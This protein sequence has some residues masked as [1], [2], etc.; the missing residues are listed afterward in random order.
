MGQDA[1]L[2]ERRINTYS[3]TTYYES[4]AP[5]FTPSGTLLRY[6]FGRA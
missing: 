6:T 3:L 1:Y 5:L 4:T 2:K